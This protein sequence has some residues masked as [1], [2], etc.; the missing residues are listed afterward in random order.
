M[1]APVFA[2]AVGVTVVGLRALPTPG[3]VVAALTA[4]EA[5]E[6]GDP[7]GL[8]AGLLL[9]ARLGDVAVGWRA[10][11]GG[12]VGVG[13]VVGAV[14]ARG[15]VVC[16]LL[17]CCGSVPILVLAAALTRTTGLRSKPESRIAVYRDHRSK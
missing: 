8:S 14:V 16:G 5:P 9:V 2:L 10:G 15:A 3:Q 7:E 4:L 17:H 12:G 6:D 11:V 1:L 13:S